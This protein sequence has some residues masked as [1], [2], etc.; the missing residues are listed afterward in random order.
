MQ[1]NL[2]KLISDLLMTFTRDNRLIEIIRV[3]ISEAEISFNYFNL[4]MPDWLYKA[5]ANASIA[6]LE[7]HIK[8]ELDV[9]VLITNLDGKPIDFLVTIIGFGDKTLIS[10]IIDTYGLAGRS[11]VFENGDITYSCEFINHVCEKQLIDNLVTG[12]L[13]ENLITVTSAHPVAS[14]VTVTISVATE[15]DNQILTLII[16]HDQTTAVLTGTF[17]SQD[18]AN[19]TDV[20]PNSDSLYNYIY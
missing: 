4:Q 16:P 13:T 1:I 10:K 11:Y 5:K 17:A 12:V 7:H 18:I 9:D 2:I 8:R 3:L 6:S 15:S 19:I 14:N 20:N